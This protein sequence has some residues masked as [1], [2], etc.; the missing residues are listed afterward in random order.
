MSETDNEYTGPYSAEDYGTCAD[1][2]PLNRFG[3]CQPL[4]DAINRI[5]DEAPNEAE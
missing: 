2:H 1:G 4:N 3:R 5:N